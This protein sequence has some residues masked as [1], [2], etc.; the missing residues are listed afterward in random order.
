MKIEITCPECE[1]LM[2]LDAENVG[3]Q[4]RCP[5]CS[6]IT[7]IPLDAKRI[8]P[9]QSEKAGSS[10]PSDTPGLHDSHFDEREPDFK[11][12]PTSSRN[13]VAFGL[14]LPIV[15]GLGL[16]ILSIVANFVCCGPYLGL[17]A[18][19]AGITYVFQSKSSLRQSGFVI[20]GLGLFVNLAILAW[21]Y[22]F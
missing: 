12:R 8:E 21:R 2:R 3:K 9:E 17:P 22:Y 20:I 16:G 1:S 7:Q 10:P 19:M 13:Q 11:N 5:V 4:A 18:A 6:T 15:Y 14:D